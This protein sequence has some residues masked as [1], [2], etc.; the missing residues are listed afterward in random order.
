M[1]NTL[2]RNN[3]TVFGEGKQT[4]IFG[5]GF[6]G[7]QSM[8]KQL[9][10]AFENNFRIILFDHVGSGASDRN[11][12]DEEKYQTL[13]GYAQDLLEICET[14]EVENAVFIGHSVS[15]MIGVLAS[16]QN[17]DYFERMV[18]IGPSPHY[19][20]DAEYKGGFEE[21]DITDLLQMMEMNYVG[22]ASHIAPIAMSNPD[23]PELAENLEK[24]FRSNDPAI[25]QKFLQATLLSDHRNDLADVTIPS[26]IIQCSDDS[27]VPAGVGEYL[28]Q[29][30]KNSQLAVMDVKGHYPH[31]SHPDETI[32]IIKKYLSNS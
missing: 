13:H 22:W 28:Q 32:A 23:R 19:L 30:L 29:N 11:S 10:P 8:F 6:G 17:P 12:F 9:T 15:A 14:L 18:M 3:V 7:D 31:I 21:T 27:F 2:S 16:I 20:N 24:S 5:H 25:T 26:L 1:K 4:L